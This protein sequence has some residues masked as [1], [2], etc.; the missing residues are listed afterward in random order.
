MGLLINKLLI[1]SL[2]SND[3]SEDPFASLKEI[4]NKII[5]NDIWAFVVQLLATAI[6]VFILAKFLVKP[7][8]KFIQERKDYIASNLN[9]AE[10]KNKKAEE[11]LLAAEKRLQDSRKE[12]K[13]II[14]S[15]RENAT[16]EKRRIVDETKKE[17]NSMRDK[18]Y[19]D[20]ESEKIKMREEI[21]N[22]VIDVAILA[23]TQ[24]VDRNLN[25]EDNR[26]IVSDFV[27]KGDNK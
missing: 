11:N 1:I 8:K 13:E 23:A 14:E 7:A 21:T 27:N 6:V 19:Q 10:E 26:K 3:A 16:Q 24:V 17:V 22:E 12:G 4:G 5:P 9:A 18:A 25:D 15:A 20:I 2:A